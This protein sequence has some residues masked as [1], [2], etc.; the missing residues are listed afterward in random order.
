MFRFKAVA[1]GVVLLLALSGC[2]TIN[3]SSAPPAGANE[4]D[5]TFAQQ[6]VPHHQ[7]ALMMS[8]MA[9]RMANSDNVRALAKRISAAQEPEIELMVGWLDDWGVDTDGH[10]HMMG[11]DGVMGMPGMMTGGTVRRLR[12]ASGDAFDRMWLRQ[13]I[14]HHEGAVE[15]AIEEQAQGENADVI[16]LAQR[17]E[18]SQTKEI[19]YMRQLLESGRR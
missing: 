5:V 14:V 1:T 2:V 16:A 18:E 8:A 4:T 12:H 19:A 7:Q 13:M 9:R 11:A 15:M 6:M 3:T 10:G 17:I